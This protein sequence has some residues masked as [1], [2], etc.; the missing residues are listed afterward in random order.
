MLNIKD[1][2]ENDN[3]VNEITKSGVY[4]PARSA[5]MHSDPRNHTFVKAIV[6][7]TAARVPSLP[8]LRSVSSGPRNQLN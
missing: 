8:T 1:V 4:E 6:S 7:P 5:P 3:V 2:A